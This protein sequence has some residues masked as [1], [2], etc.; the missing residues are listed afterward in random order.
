MSLPFAGGDLPTAVW[1][2]VKVSVL[3]AAAALAHALLRRR[4]SAATRHLVWTLAI[5]GLL[6]LPML[7]AVLPGWQVAVRLAKADV[8]DPAP[9]REQIE[10]AA[11]TF[12]R[13]AHQDL[14]TRAV[15]T[16][17]SYTLN[18]PATLPI[19]WAIALPRLYGAG[20]LLLLIQL[21]AQRLA[22]HRLSREA[23]DVSEPEWK[24]LLLECAGS[25]GVHRPVRLL[26]GRERTMPMAFGTRLPAILIPIVA[27]TWSEDRRRLVL[28]HELA[29]VARHDCLTQM[30]AAAACALYWIHPGVWLIARRLRV[31]RELAC[32]DRVLTSGTHAREYAGHLLELAY[33]LDGRR[34]PALAV[35]MARPR[36]LEGRMLAAMDAARNRA[37]PALRSRLLG[38]AIAAALLIPLAAA[39]LTVV[40]AGAEGAL[41]PS[42]TVR[43]PALASRAGAFPDRITAN[44]AL[45][46]PLAASRQSASVTSAGAQERLPGSWEIRPSITAGSVYLKI[47]EGDSSHGSAWPIERLEGLSLAQLSGAGGP[48]RFSSR[49]DAGTLTF[50]GILRNGVGAGTFAFA[51]NAT[52]PAA[53][54][55][56]GFARPTPA[57]QYTLALSDI[58]FAFLDELTTQGY[59]RPDIAALVRAGQHGVHLDYLRE[60]GRLG[61]RLGV[62]EALI[63][64]RDHGVTP[65][66]IRELAAQGLTGLSPDDLLRARDHGVDAAYVNDLR[67][68]GYGSLG[69]NQLV[70]VRDHGVSAEFIR[71][72]GQ[73]GYARLSLEALVSARDPGISPEY[74]RDLRQLGYRLT[75]DELTKARDHGVSA[76]YIRDLIALGY[77]RLALD[78]LI[79]ARDHG[80]SP[81]YVRDLSALGYRL[82]LVELTS[83]RDHGLD[84]EFIR[85]LG[86]L[87]Y[88]NQSLD[89]LI[90]LRDHGVTPEY[91]REV[92]GLGYNDLDVDGLMRL[93]DRGITRDNLRTA[94][95]RASARLLLDTLKAF[96]GGLLK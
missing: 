38:T 63:T 41:G 72:L 67:A 82:N 93:R 46:K 87:G 37:T 95:L 42:A 33:S 17:G 58:G 30:M 8:P 77:P 55:K 54:A 71:E 25:M 56:R 10:R 57:D 90:R 60:I 79:G 78:A 35:S 64:Q 69:L 20:V 94:D 92:K 48:V 22:V 36:Q 44:A 16:P 91:I 86:A 2:V 15:A 31:E 12:Q 43:S 6:L 40:P 80:I 32:D 89:S 68:L 65:Q 62:V 19:P 24:R 70:S 52:F 85:E 61:Y 66:F 59:R 49:R 51:P 96:A 27:D 21:A 28:L 14:D 11:P 53:L 45:T 75:L 84:A 18:G 88:P 81:D 9:I 73:L 5:A 13:P 29:H 23:T 1:V 76:E 4:T 74:V 34:A 3:M 50:E 26:R 83:A 39:E 47:T 7:S